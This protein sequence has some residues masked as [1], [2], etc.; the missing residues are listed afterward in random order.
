[1]TQWTE[2]FDDEQKSAE[3]VT[4][5]LWPGETIEEAALALCEEAGEVA[6]AIIKRNHAEVGSGDRAPDDWDANLRTELAQVVVVAMKMAEREGFSLIHAV[7]DELT[8][9]DQRR[10]AKGLG[11]S[12]VVDA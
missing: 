6:R 4:N 8:R 5:E 3:W 9:L 2:V 7:L 11:A 12:R 1:M 10:I